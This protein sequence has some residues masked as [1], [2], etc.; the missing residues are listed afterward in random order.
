MSLHKKDLAANESALESTTIESIALEIKPAELST[1]QR[2]RMRKRTLEMA[3]EITN[4]QAP[5]G[6]RTERVSDA[7]WVQIAPCVEIRELWRDER[8]GI[9][10]S[11]LRM[12][13]G[14]VIPAH[15]HKKE[16]DFVVLEGECR[17]GTHLLRAGD[18]HKANAQSF[19]GDVTTQ[20]GVT[21]LLRGEYPYPGQ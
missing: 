21:V 5:E 18:V 4:E 17:I 19:H 8:A 16:E 9:H 20:K 2:D 6:T 12:Q 15:R 11:L 7:T 10:V 13:P 14:G 1:E 3:H